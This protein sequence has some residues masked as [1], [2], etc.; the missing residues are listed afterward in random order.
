MKIYFLSSQPCALT[1]N[2]VFFGV[3]DLFERTAE[4]NLSDRIYAEFS[5]EGSLPIG[6]FITERLPTTP[7]EGCEVYQLTDG[8]AVYARDFP[9]RDFTLR[10][11]AQLRE[12]EFLVT[13]FQQGNC[14]LSIESQKGFF[15]AYLPPSFNPCQ[16]FLH[17]G[18]ILLKGDTALGVFT[19]DCRQLLCEKVVDYRLEEDT[20]FACLPLSD[21]RKRTAECTW[22]LSENG[23]T[24]TSFTLRQP[25]EDSPRLPTEL[26]AFAFF[27]SVL[28][29]TDFAAFLSDEL[30]LEAEQIAAFLGDFIAVTP[31][32]TPN[33]CGL[34]KRKGERLYA[35]ERYAV[36]VK[37]DKIT[38]VQG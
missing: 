12:G 26:L 31:T 14:Q 34:I 20:L 15:N 30:Q 35:V 5:P 22:Q 24:L 33:V 27:E 6:F 13:V 36:T 28:F 16:I 18:L 3:T 9:P 25:A 8:I 11:I 37:N 7:P 23:C 32:E 21:S 17:R 10:P 1:L 38:D 19:P 4:V 29:K 2:G